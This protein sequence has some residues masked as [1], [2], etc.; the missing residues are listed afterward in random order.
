MTAG[1]SGL[2]AIGSGRPR[3]AASPRRAGGPHVATSVW[4]TISWIAAPCRGRR[5]GSGQQHDLSDVAHRHGIGHRVRRSPRRCEVT[6]PLR[7]PERRLGDQLSKASLDVAVRTWA[8]RCA[9]PGDRQ[10]S[11]LSR[12]AALDGSHQ[13][14]QHARSL[15]WRGRPWCGPRPWAERSSRACTLLKC[16]VLLSTSSS[17]AT[18]PPHHPRS[19]RA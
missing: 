13:I 15:A 8:N 6:Q 5:A 16:E 9:A 19:G 2:A 11:Q 7:R 10:R 17:K 12:C 1:R 3:N 14:P 4:G 18:A